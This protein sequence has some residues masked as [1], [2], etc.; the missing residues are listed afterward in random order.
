MVPSSRNGAIRDFAVAVART[1]RFG[2]ARVLDLPVAGL[3]PDVPP[4]LLADR[5]DTVVFGDWYWRVPD[6][7]TVGVAHTVH[8]MLTV[9]PQHMSDLVEGVARTARYESRIPK[10]PLPVL[11]AYLASL[12]R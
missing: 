11:R 4:L 6:H 2:P 7:S 8:R 9:A 5:G 10:A 1:L 12:P 3:A